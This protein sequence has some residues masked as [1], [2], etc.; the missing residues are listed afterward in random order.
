MLGIAIIDRLLKLKKV[1]VRRKGEW[2]GWA[3]FY[4]VTSTGMSAGMG[5]L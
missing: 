1:V 4:K 3:K 2:G 5:H